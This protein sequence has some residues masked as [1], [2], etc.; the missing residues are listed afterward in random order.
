MP[1]YSPNLVGQAGG[2]IPNLSER[3]FPTTSQISL[4]STV[5]IDSVEVFP[6]IA[7]SVGL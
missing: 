1:Y 5:F 3:A 6:V 2:V 4:G 7:S